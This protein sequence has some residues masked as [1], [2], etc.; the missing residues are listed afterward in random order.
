MRAFSLGIRK[1]QCVRRLH[2]EHRTVPR[3]FGTRHQ[4]PDAFTMA[5]PC[6]L[7]P[8]PSALFGLERSRERNT[9]SLDTTRNAHT[10]ARTAP[11]Q[12]GSHTTMIRKHASGPADQTAVY[13][14]PL[15]ESGEAGPPAARSR[16][17]DAAALT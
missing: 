1:S 4:Q 14:T 3:T 17:W 12:G 13:P 10:S 9:Q 16:M 6:S 5:L 11:S 2:L 7:D 8:A 15:G